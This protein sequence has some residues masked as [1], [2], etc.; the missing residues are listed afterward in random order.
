MKAKLVGLEPVQYVKRDTGETVQGIKLHTIGT[1]A[2]VRG[3]FVKEIW[4]NA[5]SENLYNFARKLELDTSLDIDY[6]NYGNVID[7]SVL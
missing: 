3:T 5:R 7:I 4:I 2:N 6:N 1:N